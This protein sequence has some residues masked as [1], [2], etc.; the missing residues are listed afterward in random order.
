MQIS[1]RAKFKLL[2]CGLFALS[3]LSAC[4]GKVSPVIDDNA[5]AGALMPETAVAVSINSGAAITATS[6]VSLGLT[7]AGATAMYVTNTAECSGGGAWESFAASKSWILGQTNTTATVYVKFRNGAGFESTCT[8][9]AII[10]DSQAPDVAT[11]AASIHSEA[12][13]VDLAIT[14]LSSYTVAWSVVSG[15][16]QVVITGPNSARTSLSALSE[17]DYVVKAIVTDAAGHVTEREV[18]FTWAYCVGARLT[19]S[20]FANS[21][22]TGGPGA[23][24]RRSESAL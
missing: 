4:T 7:A 12:F 10:Q 1:L 8:S 20:P 22:E 24:Q 3:F 2:C 14:D 15:G 19:N 23:R 11:F 13:I 21:G 9:D 17:G 18:A 6:D 5:A 16:A